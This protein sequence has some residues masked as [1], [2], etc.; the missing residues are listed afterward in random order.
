MD[1]VCII[2]SAMQAFIFAQILRVLKIISVLG[3][4]GILQNY[5]NINKYSNTC[6]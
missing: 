5:V 4:L 6:Q 2:L 1:K 3:C